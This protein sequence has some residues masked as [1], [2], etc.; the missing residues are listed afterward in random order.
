MSKVKAKEFRCAECGTGSVRPVVR[1]GRRQR[2]QMIDL[3]LP[4]T[5][6]V[7][8]CDNC[9][10][11][12]LSESSAA[13]EDAALEPLYRAE[14][15]RRAKLAVDRL[16]MLVADADLERLLGLSRGY[17]SRVYTGQ[18]YPSADLVALLVMLA[19]SPRRRIDELRRSWCQDERS[20]PAA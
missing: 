14:L 11:E 4:A 7:P 9:G 19:K 20:K 10:V 17:V 6:P 1:A 15:G 18:R 5:V 16:R 8:T 12:Y 13:A 3:V 2:Y